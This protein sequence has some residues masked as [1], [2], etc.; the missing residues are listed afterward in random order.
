[1]AVARRA[2]GTRAVGHTGT[3]DPTASGVLVVVVGEATKLVNLLSVGDKRYEATLELGAETRTLDA[4]GE[5]VATAEVPT[6]SLADVEAAARGFAGEI[7]QRAPLVSAIKIA[8]KS[9]QK[10]VRAGESVEAPVRKVRVDALDIHAFDGK[11]ITFSVRCGKGFYVR[12]LARDLAEALGTLGH[13]TSLR[14][15]HNAGFALDQAVSFEE[16]RSAARGT[17]AQRDVLRARLLPLPL[18]CRRLPHATFAQGACISLR[19]G[20]A[21]NLAELQHPGLPEQ[22]ELIALSEQGQPI[23]IVQRSLD[24]LRVVRGFRDT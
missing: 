6:L 12:A 7:A 3:L 9:L 13:L 1:V 15:T 2:L 8:G 10:R 17:D 14:R 23:A 11:C 20:R 16:L 18:L 21:L 19:H 4:G 24:A 5:V 22:D